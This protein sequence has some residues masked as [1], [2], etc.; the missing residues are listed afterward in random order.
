M[1][2][3]VDSDDQNDDG[4]CE[5]EGLVLDNSSFDPTFNSYQ[6]TKKVTIRSVLKLCKKH[7]GSEHRE[8]YQKVVK[9][10]YSEALELR[11]FLSKLTSANTQLKQMQKNN[12]DVD[13]INELDQ[14]QWSSAWLS[15]ICLEFWKFGR[16]ETFLKHAK[17]M[18]SLRSGVTLNRVENH[19][20]VPV[21]FEL[22]PYEM[23][24]DDIRK[25]KYSLRETPQIPES[26][27]KDTHDI[28][29]DFIRSR[30]PLNPVRVQLSITACM[31]PYCVLVSVKL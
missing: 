13:E 15:G 30:P 14:Q 8:H 29:L 23:L 16:I 9:A 26:L 20:K 11:A 27:R 5:N 17:V 6:T 7:A 18:R 3:T 21:Q 12:T 4:Y 28:I 19:H 1:T 10:L 2:G 24:L 25:K 31:E 22:S